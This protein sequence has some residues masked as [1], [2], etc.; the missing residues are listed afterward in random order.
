MIFGGSVVVYWWLQFL[1]WQ[2][3]E[4]TYWSRIHFKS[5]YP[6]TYHFSI[7][8]TW[9]FRACFFTFLVHDRIKDS[10]SFHLDGCSLECYSFFADSPQN[11]SINPNRF[12]VQSSDHIEL[13]NSFDS[14]I[15]RLFLK[16]SLHCRISDFY[17]RL[18]PL[19][20]KLAETPFK[21]RLICDPS[22]RQKFHQ[23]L[24]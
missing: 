21:S 20:C 11:P 8:F 22:S 7:H 6:M 15:K 16:F 14:T 13:F 12:Q 17:R 3:A 24:R 10:Y 23:F 5:N 4:S 2:S 9:Q 1:F 19:H 18:Q